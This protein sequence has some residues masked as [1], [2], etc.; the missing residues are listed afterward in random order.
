MMLRTQSS[1][2]EEKYQPAKQE[3]ERLGISLRNVLPVDDSQPWMNYAGMVE[4]ENT[5]SSQSIDD[6]LWSQ[7]LMSTSKSKTQTDCP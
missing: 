5:Q 1:L 3:A 6:G 4:S 7:R 2:S